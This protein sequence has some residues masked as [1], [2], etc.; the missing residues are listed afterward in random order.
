MG[1]PVI[2]GPETTDARIQHT[3][4]AAGWFTAVP[5]WTPAPV[6]GTAQYE[7]EIPA[8]LTTALR[9]LARDLGVTPSSTLLCAHLK[10]LSAL[11]GVREVGCGYVAVPGGPALPL[12]L[13]LDS[14]S[15][16]ALLLATHQAASTSAMASASASA[17]APHR[18]LP[19][20]AIRTGIG[21]PA[22]SPEA[23]FDPYGDGGPETDAALRVSVTARGSRCLLRLRYRT[24]VLDGECAARI[25]GYHLTAL[26]LM[27]GDPHADP[28]PQSLVGAA[29]LH[30]QV[31]GLAGPRRNLPD[32]RAHELFEQRAH[33][34]PDA[35]AAV[36]E[37]RYWTYGELNAR[38]N[39]LAH[40]LLK[41]GLRREDAVA[42]VCERSLGWMAA[43]LAVLKAGGAYV[44]VEPHFPADRITTMLTRSSCRFALVESGSTAALDRALDRLAE[45]R[46]VAIDAACEDVR[47]ADDP[48]VLIPADSLAYIYFTSGSTGEPKGVMCEHAGMLNHLH[49]K[50]DDLD[51]G[52]GATVAQTAPQC[53]DISLWQ[54]LAG[55][56]AGGRTLLVGQETVLDVERF[57]DTVIAGRAT[58][59]QV[60]PSYLDAVLAS[61]ERTPRDL[62]DLRCVS[63]TGEAVTKELVERWFARLPGIRLVNAYGL[64]ETSDDTNHEVMDRVPDSDRVPLGRPVGN[65]RVYVLGPNLEPVPMGA[66]GEIV[67]SGV[68]VGRG[69][70]G[71]PERTRLAFAADP[72]HPGS[73]IYRSG[74]QGRWLPD[75]KLEFLGRRDTQVKIRGFR[76]EL[77]EIEGALVRAPGVRA[78]AVVAARRAGQEP[79]LV[80]FCTGAASLDTGRL[81]DVLGTSL[82][83]YMVPSAFHRLERLPVTANGKTDTKA[84]LALAEGRGEPRDDPRPP[85]TPAERRLAAAWSRSLGIPVERIGRQDGFFDLGGTSLSAL[86]VVVAL[87]REISFKDLTRHPCLAD[88]A[89]LLDDRVPTCDSP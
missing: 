70:V 4:P 43:V 86:R 24:E 75:G 37:G 12:R 47:S 11:S 76:I 36:Q 6:P 27:V 35:V 19:A 68:C 33:A 22:S 26:A 46:I 63:V 65:V 31:V 57:L 87:G 53:F 56:L 1:T 74:D 18:D 40:A 2:T 82:P 28:G 39:R 50:I 38:A 71:D 45:V 55:P 58:V 29:E 17:T 59:L 30:H 77:G 7:E 9:R 54:L 5:R 84:L 66:P 51:I 15:W 25:T 67:F 3:P 72:H 61:L 89:R 41:L 52:E 44:P 83:A 49:A 64:T 10:V 80:A 79:F 32:L 23:V 48:R 69:Y 42:V 85:R 8:T 81:R 14:R 21:F 16:R 60:V 34:H 73:R 78:A 88:L 13:S 20:G 62:P